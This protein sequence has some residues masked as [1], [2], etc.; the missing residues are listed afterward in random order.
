MAL[1]ANYWPDP[2]VI[3]VPMTANEWT[4]SLGSMAIQEGYYKAPGQGSSKGRS[5][6]GDNSILIESHK[7]LTNQYGTIMREDEEHWSYDVVNGP[8]QEYNRETKWGGYLPGIGRGLRVVETVKVIY[9][10]FTPWTDGD[11][12]GRTR[13]ISAYCV[14]DLPVEPDED[15]SA[16]AKQKATDAG[17]IPGNKQN[18]I[19]QTGR[20]WSEGNKNSS[21]VEQAGAPQ[22]VKWVDEVIVEHDVVVEQLDR[23]Q[24]WTIVKNKLKPQDV[25]IKG[26]RDIKKTGFAYQYPY[27]VDPPKIK[28][29][30]RA[31][32]I[33]V[34]IRGGGS[35]IRNPYFGERG[36]IDI[37]ADKYNV[38]R[39]KVTDPPRTGDPDLYDRW[40]A[41]PSLPEERTIIG[42]TVVEE[43]DG[44]PASTLPSQTSYTEPGDDTP[45]EEPYE[46]TFQLIA[47]VDNANVAMRYDLAQ[48]EFF[49]QDVVDGA[50]YE[51]YAT[52]IISEAESPDSNHETIIYSGPEHHQYRMGMLENERGA[53][54][55]PPVDPEIPDEDYGEV[56]EFDVPLDPEEGD[57]QEVMDEIAPRVFAQNEPDFRI[58]MD[59]LMPLLGLEYG[60]AVEL[61]VI[62]WDVYANALHIGQETQND[63]WMLVGFK[64]KFARTKEG[65]WT[66][67]RTQLSLQERTRN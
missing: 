63:D 16:E 58:D 9:W 36:R 62:E 4:E 20:I 19:L 64:M 53:D 39:K 21:F 18:L 11:N 35:T 44:T 60:Q 40:V 34:E 61:P 32:G 6:G 67:Q 49:D 59:V 10:T 23:W 13:L 17:M 31:E 27:P 37:P 38:Y 33:N 48:G 1:V 2:V 45:P 5:S 41:D 51:Y 43:F 55:T 24:I 30:N 3:D 57:L 54:A 15:A 28:L 26:P 52:A 25:Q 42:D 50:E 56:E 46:T 29:Q 12:L 8:T 14:Y 47:T 65:N 22:M 7:T 66:S